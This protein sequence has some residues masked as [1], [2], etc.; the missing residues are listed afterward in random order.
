MCRP[1]P[2]G[3]FGPLAIGRLPMDDCRPFFDWLARRSDSSLVAG[4]LR[5]SRFPHFHVF[6][7]GGVPDSTLGRSAPLPFES[8]GLSLIPLQNNKRH[9]RRNA[10]GCLINTATFAR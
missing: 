6:F 9:I 8:D 10:P 3:H 7:F 4:I 5:F 1:G 2:E